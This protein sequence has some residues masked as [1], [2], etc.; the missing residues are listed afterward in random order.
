MFL[1]SIDANAQFLSVCRDLFE[2]DNMRKKDDS[3]D[4]SK[5]LQILRDAGFGPELVNT[6][7]SSA[8]VS[9]TRRGPADQLSW[10]KE[11]RNLCGQLRV[12]Q[13]FSVSCLRLASKGPP[14]NSPLAAGCKFYKFDIIIAAISFAQIKSST[15]LESA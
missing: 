11:W 14:T 7:K 15:F 1:E 4:P 9:V 6:L 10:K 13:Q 8:K 2:Q 5:S 12:N 3:P